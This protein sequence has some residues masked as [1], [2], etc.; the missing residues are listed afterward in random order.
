MTPVRL[1]SIVFT[2]FVTL[3]SGIQLMY[4]ARRVYYAREKYRIT[5]PAVTGN[6]AFER[7][8]TAQQNTLE[9]YPVFMTSL[10]TSSLFLHQV[11][12]SICGLIYMISRHRY[13]DGCSHSMEERQ[14]GFYTGTRCLVAMSVMAAVGLLRTLLR[15]NWA[16]V[17]RPVFRSCRFR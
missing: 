17:T 12:A 5:Y 2:G 15:M 13:F 9:W 4:F 3:G 10:W 14:P 11:P 8:Y 16:D 7:I 6:V 1:E